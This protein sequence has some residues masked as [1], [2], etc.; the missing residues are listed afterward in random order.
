M[1]MPTT[2]IVGSG[3]E[4]GDPRLQDTTAHSLADGAGVGV[5][6]LAAPAARCWKT[7]D[8]GTRQLM[9]TAAAATIN[10]RQMDAT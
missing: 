5:T 4:G 7:S 9:V 6:M 3:T 8:A 1:S 10:Q 2:E